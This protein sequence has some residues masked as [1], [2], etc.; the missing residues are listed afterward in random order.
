MLAGR[1]CADGVGDRPV[2]DEENCAPREVASDR[3]RP[4]RERIDRAS[5]PARPRDRWSGRATIAGGAPVEP[6]QL[7]VVW[8]PRFRAYD[9]GSGHPFTEASRELAVVLL[10]RSIDESGETGVEWVR[11]VPAA[12]ASTL[13]Q[14]HTE[15]YL[16]LV[17]TSSRT[18]DR[19]LLDRA[20]TPS[21]PGCYEASARLV[22]GAVEATRIAVE[23]GNPA[24]HPAGGLHH[25]RPGNASGFC[26]FNDVAVAIAGEL[27]HGRTVAYLD[28][29]A[30]HGD[31]VMYG[32]FDSGRLLDIDFHQDGRTIFPGT[33]FP[34]ETG[35]GD[36]AGL[37]VNVPLP[38]GAGDEAL[39]P[40]FHRLVPPLLES[41]HPDLLVIQ[42]GV[43]GHWGD[44][45]THLQY[46]RDA[47]AEILSACVRL[48]REHAQGKL[49]VVGGGGYRAAS[50]ARVLAAAGLVLSGRNVPT[51]ASEVPEAWRSSYERETRLAAPTTWGETP[52]VPRS[53]WTRSSEESLVSE[54]E[55]ALGRRFPSP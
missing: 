6:K 52:S 18:G 42:H 26:V 37:K 38:P 31:G 41:F 10:D 16:S 40:L 19:R 15:R 43:D 24:F 23:S 5:A 33:G 17:E 9:F 30:H 14:F 27:A 12:T 50:V 39:V 51:A 13:T 53:P 36:G 4:A 55:R 44:P 32:F 34:D 20:D 45:L 49:V 46:T 25:A 48:A 22:E 54:L 7:T 1:S 11:R 2:D 35:R 28:L 47:F 29:D 3:K 8:D 21:F